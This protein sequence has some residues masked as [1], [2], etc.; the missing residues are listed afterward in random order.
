MVHP[1]APPSGRYDVDKIRAD[2]P[3]LSMEVHGKPLVFLDNAASTQKPRAVIDAVERYYRAENA[4][5]HRGVYYLSEV[6]TKKYEDA[7]QTVQQFLNAASTREIIFTSGTTDSIN[8]VAAAYGRKFI[9][10]GDE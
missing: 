3:I 9:K 5:I 1:K 4:N 2:F 10:E 8:L 6:A 7:R